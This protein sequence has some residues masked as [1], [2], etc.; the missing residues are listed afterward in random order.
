MTMKKQELWMR[1]MDG[2]SVAYCFLL[3]TLFLLYNEDGFF[4]LTEAKFH[5]FAVL[6]RLYIGL[7][8]SIFIG[9]LFFRRQSY[10]LK[11]MLH[12]LSIGDW[13][14]LGLLASHTITLLF[15]P[16]QSEAF[17][18]S[19]GRHMGYEF[20]LLI[21]AVYFLLSRTLIHHQQRLF[22]ILL[23]TCTGISVLGI[24]NAWGFDPLHFYPH[25]AGTEAHRY[26]A[27]VGNATFFAQLMCL[28]TSFSALQF[29]KAKTGKQRLGYGVVMYCG[30]GALIIAHIDGA[31]L[32]LGA[33]LLYYFY[34]YVTNRPGLRDFFI[35]IALFCAAV[36]TVQFSA[37]FVPLTLEGISLALLS[38]PGN[39]VMF[40]LLVGLIAGIERKPS[41]FAAL[42][43]AKIR[44]A[45]MIIV[46]GVML[47]LIVLICFCTLT[48]FPLP[49]SLTP[50]LRFDDAWGS[51]RGRLWRQLSALYLHD[52]SGFQQLFGQ[53]LDCT[54]LIL[55]HALGNAYAV[56][57]NAHNEYLQYL[58]TTGLCGLSLYLALLG[59]FIYRLNLHHDLPPA[60]AIAAML[61]AYGASAFTS[62]NQPITT[63]LLFL[64]M[65]IAESLLRTSPP[66]AEH[67]RI[68]E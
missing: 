61:I 11:R 20:S 45:I 17:S 55:T 39:A 38:S 4:H 30:F 48:R 43:Y 32:G 5:C 29:G 68:G 27:T 1:V 40:C 16:Y 56:F 36:L 25:I 41:V 57:D 26:L 62:L 67:R 10:S 59:S 50:Y 60:A 37:L 28:S 44:K 53:G 66:L 3:F 58:I 54:R 21:T 14:M 6:S 46:I 19:S 47:G 31:Y 22:H 23:C 12:T 7:N 63:P 2:V 33:F 49:A 24:I 13:C 9:G 51:Q 15:S 65:A 64:F 52:F 8:G 18:G 34:R 42:P 35:V